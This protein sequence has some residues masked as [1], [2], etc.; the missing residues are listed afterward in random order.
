MM[1]AD[2]TSDKQRIKAQTKIRD[3]RV[4][5]NKSKQKSEKIEL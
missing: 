5:P 2:D 3:L 4:S 1:A